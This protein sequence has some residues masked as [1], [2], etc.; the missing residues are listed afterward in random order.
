MTITEL[1]AEVRRLSDLIDA[2]IAQLEAAAQSEAQAEH[3][4]RLVKARA[5]VTHP[6]GTVPERT[7]AVDAATAAS[8][9][10]R[11]L[12]SGQ[13]L[14]ALESLRSRRQQ[15]SAAQ[16]VSAAF[17]AEAELG[18]YGTQEQP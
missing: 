12:A 9:R 17:R 11:D 5:W 13:K 14:A 15:L 7:A 2:G 8:R 1:I 18:R 4:Y 16:S 3:A 10:A 6:D